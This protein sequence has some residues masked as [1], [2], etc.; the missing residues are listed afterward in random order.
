MSTALGVEKPIS[1]DSE[2]KPQIINSGF[3]Q[4]VFVVFTSIN[5]TLNVL[6][7]ASQLAKP[8]QGGIEVLAIQTV[9]YSLPL[10]DPSVPSQFLVSRLEEMAAQFPEQ[11]KI[12][13][14]LCR[15]LL[16]ALKRILNRNCAVVMGVRKRWWPTRDQR[17]ARK[18]RRAGYN[19]IL[20]E[21]R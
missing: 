15:D 7:K 17:A 21:S 18:L 10:E 20:V 3:V 6:E 11:I 12:S 2:T 14:Y 5:R 4:P 16:D 9:P 1:F 8:L 13:A 19:V